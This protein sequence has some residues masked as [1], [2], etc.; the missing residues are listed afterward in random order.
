MVKTEVSARVS[1]W[2]FFLNRSGLIGKRGNI[3][4]RERAA[5]WRKC[6]GHEVPVCLRT[7]IASVAKQSRVSP[8][9]HFWIASLRSHDGSS[10]QN[11]KGVLPD[12][13][14]NFSLL[15]KTTLL[16]ENNPMHSRTAVDFKEE[17]VR[18]A[19]RSDPNSCDLFAEAAGTMNRADLEPTLP[20]AIL[21]ITMGH[22]AKT[23]NPEHAS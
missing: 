17:I 10:G 15:S 8:W 21:T 16:Y 11:P 2:L 5:G 14:S 12:G 7:V 23:P 22:S 19:K 9:M 18:W 4:P 1:S 6:G 3:P 13:T 20:S